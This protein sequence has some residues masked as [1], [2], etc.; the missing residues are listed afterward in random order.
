MMRS[1]ADLMADLDPRVV[2]APSCPFR[3]AA[4][5]NLRFVVALRGER[6]PAP[7]TQ[8]FAR[9]EETLRLAA[10][11]QRLIVARIDQARRELAGDASRESTAEERRTW[12]AMLR[13]E[14]D[15]LEHDGA[16][17]V[18]ATPGAAP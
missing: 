3:W 18:G 4:D 14:A 10:E 13:S 6:D 7:G 2:L 17:V 8:E 11:T 9:D 15:R 12:A 5:R 16:V 1:A